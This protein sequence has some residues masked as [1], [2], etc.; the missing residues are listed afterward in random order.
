MMFWEDELQKGIY[1]K[2]V[3]PTLIIFAMKNRFRDTYGE[4]KQEIN[5][6]NNFLDTNVPDRVLEK[7]WLKNHNTK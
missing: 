6:T 4:Q 5:V 1:N 7:D 3:N 2:N